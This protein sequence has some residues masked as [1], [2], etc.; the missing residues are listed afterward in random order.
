MSAAALH[1]W[2]MGLH[3]AID[4]LFDVLERGVAKPTP[5]PRGRVG[6]RDRT[7][8]PPQTPYV[9]LSIHTARDGVLPG[10]SRHRAH[11]ERRSSS[12]RG[13]AW[14]SLQTATSPSLLRHY[15]ALIATMG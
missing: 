11:A 2:R 9:N 14:V 4:A 13:L 1:L 7:S 12:P 5:T 15:S 10:T 6:R 3:A 8:S